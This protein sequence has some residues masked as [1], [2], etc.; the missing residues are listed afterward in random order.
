MKPGVYCF[1]WRILT[2]ILEIKCL[3]ETDI[4][5]NICR[6]THRNGCCSCIFVRRR[7]HNKTDDDGRNL[8]KL[9]SGAASDGRV[10]FI[11]LL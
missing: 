7:E 4:K 10:A 5:D 3:Q 1:A 6:L 11:I 8:I 9:S 2:K